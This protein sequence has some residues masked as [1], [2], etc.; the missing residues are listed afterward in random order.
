MATEADYRQLISDVVITFERIFTQLTN[1]TAGYVTHEATVL[2]EVFSDIPELAQA[3]IATRNALQSTLTVQ[4]FRNWVDP[5][6]RSLGRLKGYPET[7]I[8]L[9]LD[10]W[11]KDNVTNSVT[12]NTRSPVFGSITQTGTGTGNIFRL[13]RDKY[14]KQ[15]DTIWPE[16][17]YFVCTNDSLNG[18]TAHEEIFQYTGTARGKDLL[19]LAGSGNLTA[20]QSYSA[21][22]SLI[23]NPSFSQISGTT[24]TVDSFDNWTK[25]SGTL[26]TA[27]GTNYF[28]GFQ[29]DSTPYAAKFSADC[30]L[31]QKLS[32][33]RNSFD[34]NTPYLLVAAYNRSI[35]SG[36]G[37]FTIQLG[38][39]TNSVTL[40][41]ASS[42]WQRLALLLT[43]ADTWF[44]NWN[45]T[46]ASVKLTISGS[47]GYTLVDD[48]LLV[49]MSYIGGTWWA[50]CG[51]ATLFL[52]DD[53]F[54]WTDANS[55]PYRGL[56]SKWF[57]WSYG[58][59]PAPAASSPTWA[60][61]T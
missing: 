42:G 10:H 22:N 58:R 48:V 14:N 38:S 4:S 57:W 47:S 2:N 35:G 13:T 6:I 37:T 3:T 52:K 50:I 55:D 61:G 56:N 16:A 43:N 36:T 8:S 17:K 7:D 25:D 34:P 30:V 54:A 23:L 51:G 18:A 9:I 41:S 15:V 53:K 33:S 20:M 26:P 29:G 40:A 49:P 59:L 12:I 5:I 24:P 1:S 28:R 39:K 32:L 11:Y 19:Q 27:E 60:D 46:D 45:T 21:R 31:S 44:D